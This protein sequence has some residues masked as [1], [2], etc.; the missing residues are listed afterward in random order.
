MVIIIIPVNL[1]AYIGWQDVLVPMVGKFKV[2][3]DWVVTQTE[4]TVYITDKPIDEEGYKIYLIGAIYPRNDNVV[5][6]YELFENTRKIKDGPG[7][8]YSN[9]AFYGQEEYIINGKKETKYI[10]DVGYNTRG[11]KSLSFI[12]WDDIIDEKTLSRIAYSFDAVKGQ[13]SP[14]S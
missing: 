13:S 10:L 3:P 1:C 5:F 4:D 9:G 8:G 14:K 2:P 6:P 11:R 7:T 12:A